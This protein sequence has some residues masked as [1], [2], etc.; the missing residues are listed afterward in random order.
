MKKATIF[1]LGVSCVSGSAPQTKLLIPR[2]YNA[3]ATQ[4]LQEKMTT[5][6]KL[7]ND[8]KT[9]TQKVQ[10]SSLNEIE[11][12][13]KDKEADP[14]TK[15]HI[16]IAFGGEQ[17]VNFFEFLM[18]IVLSVEESDYQLVESIIKISLQQGM[19]IRIEEGRANWFMKM[20]R[21][22]TRESPDSIRTI[23]DLVGNPQLKEQNL[24]M[25]K[26]ALQD[27]IA[28][29][30]VQIQDIKN[31]ADKVRKIL[32]ALEGIKVQPAVVNIKNLK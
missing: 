21:M 30:Q 27:D 32:E 9:A 2:R 4:K 18:A 3:E 25:L 16:K 1:V 14:N 15:V 6:L 26:K 7:L 20:M 5:I 11:S 8:M 24:N 22:L 28:L 12:L 23:L 10:A 17:D 19:N 29:E 13:I 31:E